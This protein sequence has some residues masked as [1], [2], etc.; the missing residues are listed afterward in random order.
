ML[1]D[2][3]F[4]DSIINLSKHFLSAFTGFISIGFH[5]NYKI[6]YNPWH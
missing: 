4:P 5:G 3:I 2:F 6:V 1:S